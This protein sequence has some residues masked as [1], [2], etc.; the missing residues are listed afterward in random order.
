MFNCSLCYDYQI[1]DI[2]RMDAILRTIVGS[3]KQERYV[4]NIY[5]LRRDYINISI[6]LQ[7]QKNMIEEVIHKRK[8]YELLNA[9]RTPLVYQERIINS[10]RNEI[11][12]IQRN[13]I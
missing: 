5:V 10:I 6:T 7:N 11:F 4:Q 1:I 12:K 3:Y 2:Q 8:I 9:L 13:L